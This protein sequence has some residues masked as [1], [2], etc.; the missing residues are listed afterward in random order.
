MTQYL[1]SEDGAR[2]LMALF[3]ALSVLA[4]LTG[5]DKRAVRASAA[6]R[7]MREYERAR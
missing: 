5:P 1:M 6:V 4:F 7:G 2:F 3:A